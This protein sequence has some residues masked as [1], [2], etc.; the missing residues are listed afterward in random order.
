M[1]PNA[2]EPTRARRPQSQTSGVADSKRHL[3]SAQ[4]ATSDMAFQQTNNPPGNSE[5]IARLCAQLVTSF[6]ANDAEAVRLAYRELL[7]LGRPRAEILAEVARIAAA[8][9]PKPTAPGSLAKAIAPIEVAAGTASVHAR[10]RPS[11]RPT[12]VGPDLAH[13]SESSTEARTVQRK[14]RRGSR[15]PRSNMPT[16]L[17]APAA[18]FTPLGAAAATA[19]LIKI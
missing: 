16:L 17:R 1:T 2:Q 12:S 19:I 5:E 6:G 4:P 13:Q 11:I 8:Q 7:R 3:K 14:G 15:L 18:C 9:E 10:S